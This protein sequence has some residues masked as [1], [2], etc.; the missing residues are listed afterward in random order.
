M[1]RLFPKHRQYF[2][3]L[4]FVRLVARNLAVTCY[5]VL[6]SPCMIF[7]PSACKYL[8]SNGQIHFHNQVKLNLYAKIGHFQVL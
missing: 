4:F 2:E 7:W 5:V 8:Y 1:Q 3:P 6:S